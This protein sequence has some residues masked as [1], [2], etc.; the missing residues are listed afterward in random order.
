MHLI[1]PA[2]WVITTKTTR[3]RTTTTTNPPTMKNRHPLQPKP[4]HNNNEK[5]RSENRY[6]KTT[7]PKFESTEKSK[8]VWNACEKTSRAWRHATRKQRTTC[9]LCNR[10]VRSL[11]MSWNASTVND[12]SSRLPADL[13]MLWG[14]GHDWITTTSSRGLEWPSIWP[15]WPSWGYCRE[16][17]IRPSFTCKLG[18]RTG[19]F[20][21]RTL[22]VWMNKFE[23]LEKSLN[24]LWPTQNSLFE[25]ESR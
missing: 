19:E 12:L 16:R 18:K 20:P 25:L 10:S 3:T 24:C 6:W 21:L 9:R 23:N 15:P 1:L 14:V 17:S 22:V 4:K 2:P 11:A 7:A 5:F 8:L 13:A